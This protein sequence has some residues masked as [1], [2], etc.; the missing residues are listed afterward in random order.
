MSRLFLGIGSNLGDRLAFLRAGCERLRNTD[1]LCVLRV[2]PLYET[3][4]IG[5]TDQGAFLNGVIECLSECD[6]RNLMSILREI[7][8]SVGRVARGRWEPRELDIDILYYGDLV[9][10]S[11]IVSI[12]HPEIPHRRFVLQPLCDLAPGFP[13]PLRGTRIMDLLMAC[14]GTEQVKRILDTM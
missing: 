11:S 12:P 2:S 7:E 1:A 13:D 14:R 10:S 8:R 6:P 3:D 4:P 5:K 9:I